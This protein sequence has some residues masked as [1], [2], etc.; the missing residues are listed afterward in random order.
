[1]TKRTKLTHAMPWCANRNV[2]CTWVIYKESY[3]GLHPKM[4]GQLSEGGTTPKHRNHR[5]SQTFEADKHLAVVI[6]D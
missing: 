5:Q 4:Q 2:V 1:M 6:D 3:N